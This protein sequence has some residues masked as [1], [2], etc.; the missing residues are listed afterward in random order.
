MPKV[1][2]KYLGIMANFHLHSHGEFLTNSNCNIYYM[3]LQVQRLYCCANSAMIIQRTMYNYATKLINISFSTV[4]E[5]S[6]NATGIIGNTYI[7]FN[8][9]IKGKFYFS[10]INKANSEISFIKIC[11]VAKFNY[12]RHTYKLYIKLYFNWIN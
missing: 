9:Q 10:S 2:G 4:H 7:N 3:Y 12:Q 1:C 6:K 8:I 5:G 11:L